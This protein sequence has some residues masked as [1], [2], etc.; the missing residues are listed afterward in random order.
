MVSMCMYIFGLKFMLRLKTV[1]I[2][3]IYYGPRASNI[4]SSSEDDQYHISIVVEVDNNLFRVA[5]SW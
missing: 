5:W 1:N 4:S 2:S 3:F